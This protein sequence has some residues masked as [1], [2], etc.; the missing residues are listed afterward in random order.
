MA[1]RISDGFITVLGKQLRIREFQQA[2]GANRPTLVFLHEGLGSIELW[3]DFTN[4]LVERTGLN[5]LVY[6]R[7][8]YGQSD[9]LDLPRPLDYLEIEAQQYLPALLEQLSI[10]KPILLGHSDGGT[11]ALVYASLYS[12]SLLIAVAAHIFVEDVTIDGIYKV[13]QSYKRET[14]GKQLEKYHGDKAHD[15]FWAWADTWLHKGFRNWNVTEFLPQI[16]CPTLLVQGEEDEY[17]T[18]DQLEQIAQGIGQHAE[19]LIL[20]KCGHSPHIQAKQPLLDNVDK[21][22]QRYINH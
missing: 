12:T 10:K 7:Q 16:N 13:A 20:K 3:K 19:T 6:E 8:G 1:L 11:I 9:L 17:A 15:L 2:S 18:L 14:L 22:I 4:L 21:F 5:A